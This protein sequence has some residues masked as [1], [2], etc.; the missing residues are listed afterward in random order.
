MA[1]KTYSLPSSGEGTAFYDFEELP[2]KADHKKFKERYR[3]T[4]DS[5]EGVDKDKATDIV[6]E[7]N[8]A[9]SLNTNLFKYLDGLMGITPTEPPLAV[10]A[11][12]PAG[13][14]QC[15]F[16]AMAGKLPNPHIHDKHKK[17]ENNNGLAYKTHLVLKPYYS[18][19]T[20]LALV[21]FVVLV[22]VLLQKLF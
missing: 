21:L 4:L 13:A 16:A 9:F 20:K 5:L 14:A 12:T 18:V 3:E 22:A 7:A 2:S 15:P 8:L 6:T 19:I 11:T 1:I 10:K 17:V